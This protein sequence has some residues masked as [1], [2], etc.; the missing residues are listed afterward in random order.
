MKGAIILFLL[1]SVIIFDTVYVFCLAMPFVKRKLT[2][3][4][5]KF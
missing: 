5:R 2:E 4:W 3:F 1:L